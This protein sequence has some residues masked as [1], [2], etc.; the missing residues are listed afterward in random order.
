MVCM[1]QRNSEGTFMRTR[2]QAQR[3]FPNKFD[4]QSL[5]NTATSTKTK[6]A[7][8]GPDPAS[9]AKKAKK[10]S[11]STVH[12]NLYEFFENPVES[13]IMREIQNKQDEL[14]A[15]CS[16]CFDQFISEK[17]KLDS[18]RNFGPT[19]IAL[20]KKEINTELGLHFIE[21]CLDANIKAK[22]KRSYREKIDELKKGSSM[23]HDL[24]KFCPDLNQY[25]FKIYFVTG[26]MYDIFYNL[27]NVSKFEKLFQKYLSEN[28]KITGFFLNILL[29]KMITNEDCTEDY[30]QHKT[31]FE[32]VIGSIH[33]GEYKAPEDWA[34]N[35]L[36]DAAAGKNETIHRTARSWSSHHLFL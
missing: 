34:N 20:S 36:Q 3:E 4:V 8:N 13:N 16:K 18:N 25:D 24:L 26:L 30:N 23:I 32:K 1:K 2:L 17:L 9:P 35:W 11:G 19:T 14:H 10:E 6:R 22:L 31:L 15:K 28:V 5:A 33:I 21:S 12:Q 29:A 7:A 27:D